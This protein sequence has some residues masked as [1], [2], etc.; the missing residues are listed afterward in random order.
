MFQ[1]HIEA[2]LVLLQRIKATESRRNTMGTIPQVVAEHHPVLIGVGNHQAIENQNSRDTG[3][4]DRA[5]VGGTINGTGISRGNV[6]A[7]I[8]G[9]LHDRARIYRGTVG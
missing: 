4:A 9:A 6:R 7:P 1:L 2:K 3:V 5:R 8:L